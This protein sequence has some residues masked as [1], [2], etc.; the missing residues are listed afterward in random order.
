RI[1]LFFDTQLTGCRHSRTGGNPFLKFGNCFSN[2]GFSSFKADSR[3]AGMTEFDD[4]PH[5]KL[6]M[7]AITG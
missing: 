1:T 2:D 3:Y 6:S 4:M 5:L 7:F